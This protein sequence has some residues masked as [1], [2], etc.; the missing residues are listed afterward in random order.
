RQGQS[1]R[2]HESQATPPP[3]TPAPRAH[4]EVC[5]VPSIVIV[6]GHQ[7]SDIFPQPLLLP[8]PLLTL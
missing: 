2:P 8:E 3:L 6:K 1:K 7:Y 5:G 4:Q